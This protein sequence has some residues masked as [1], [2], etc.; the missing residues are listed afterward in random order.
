MTLTLSLADTK[1]ANRKTLISYLQII[2]SGETLD[3]PFRSNLTPITEAID[4]K[5]YVME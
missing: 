2:P 5:G 3:D 1:I 4:Y